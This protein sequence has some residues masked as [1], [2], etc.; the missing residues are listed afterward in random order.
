MQH[1]RPPLLR[2]NANVR[3]ALAVVFLF[4]LAGCGSTHSRLPA[5]PIV[6]RTLPAQGLIVEKHGRVVL[7][8]LHGRR[9]ASL[10][11]YALHP[12]RESVGF[13]FLRSRPYTPLLHGPH[14]WYRLDVPRH[15]LLPVEG[16]RLPLASGASVVA[17]RLTEQ[18]VPLFKVEKRGRVVLRGSAPTFGVLSPRLVQ[19][20]KTLLDVTSG[21][22]WRL[23]PGCLAAGFR[24]KALDLACGVAQGAKAMARLA[25]V[26]LDPHGVAHPLAPALA[27]LIPDAALLSPNGRWLAV[28]GG[29]GCAASYVYIVPSAGGRVRIVYGKSLRNPFASNYSTLL[30]WSIDGRLVVQI[31][32]PYCDEPYG[33]QHPPNGVYLV[34]PRTLARTHVTR[35][36]D[37][38]W[39][40]HR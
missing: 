30:G 20:G 38:M 24:R 33:P 18:H 40:S 23:P 35:T 17:S 37:A 10:P 32:P 28:E 15:A 25:L 5:I 12:I 14:G 16:G 31:T 36:A 27:L 34:D 4:A 39:S 26:R 29:M 19:A 6:L 2:E 21:H 11:G 1:S 9:L 3:W 13:E 22:R 8:D 7:L